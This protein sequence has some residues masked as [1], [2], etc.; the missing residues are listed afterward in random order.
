LQGSWRHRND[1]WFV[2]LADG[3]RSNPYADIDEPSDNEKASHFWMPKVRCI[4]GAINFDHVP[5]ANPVAE[6]PDMK[7]SIVT[8]QQIERAKRRGFDL[9]TMERKRKH[10]AL[11]AGS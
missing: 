7:K 1:A 3:A 9:N 6:G 11:G 4:G 8:Q 5:G 10:L 2:L